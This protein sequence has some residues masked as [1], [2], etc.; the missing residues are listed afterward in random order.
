M[1]TPTQ[2]TPDD[3]RK[4]AR[5]EAVFNVCR[6]KFGQQ[7]RAWAFTGTLEGGHPTLGVAEY[8]I[9]GFTPTYVYFGTFADADRCA[10]SLNARMGLSKEDASRIV[11]DTMRRPAGMTRVERLLH[12]EGLMPAKPVA[13]EPDREPKR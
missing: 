3:A 5:V 1:K 10:G 8:G 12:G 6:E 7:G 2:Q 13:K 11:L 9:G 4:E